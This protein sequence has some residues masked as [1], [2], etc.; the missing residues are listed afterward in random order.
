MLQKRY[1]KMRKVKRRS[2]VRRPRT[3]MKKNKPEMKIFTSVYEDFAIYATLAA[4][5]TTSSPGAANL[6]PDLLNRILPGTGSNQRV[7]SRI[8]VKKIQ[9]SGIIFLC[10]QG[11]SASL[12]S[13]LV[14]LVV[15][16]AGWGTTGGS[17]IQYFFDHP[18]KRIFNG[19]LNRRRYSFFK[20]KIISLNS[21]WPAST[22]A[23]GVQDPGTGLMKHFNITI[24]VNKNVKYSPDLTTVPDEM[25]SYCLF[26]FGAVVQPSN[27][28]TRVACMSLR[29]RVWYTD[30]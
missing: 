13:A 19:S 15:C 6:Y 7:G 2:T 26:A 24:N 23:S 21:G 11:N 22:N 3:G 18:L 10:P 29:T 8:F 27:T 9:Y 20:D 4:V 28:E 25:N 16:S 12:N 5:D 17:S 30:D 1:R 14:R